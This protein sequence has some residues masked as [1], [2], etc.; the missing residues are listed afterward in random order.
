MSR[1]DQTLAPR[2]DLSSRE[3]LDRSSSRIHSAPS[4]PHPPGECSLPISTPCGIGTGHV[5][6]FTPVRTYLRSAGA[7]HVCE[8]A[9]TPPS[10]EPRSRYHHVGMRT[11][12]PDV[13]WSPVLVAALRIRN[14][15]ITIKNAHVA[16]KYQGHQACKNLTILITHI[17]AWS[18]QSNLIGPHPAKGT[19][20]LQPEPLPQ[21]V[22]PCMD[23][24][25]VV[26]GF[27]NHSWKSSETNTDCGRMPP[28][29]RS[30]CRDRP[31]TLSPLTGASISDA[32]STTPCGSNS[33]NS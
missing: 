31:V 3:N 4:A 33:A 23:G 12:V 30:I 5:R 27:D 18:W 13:P 32:V 11:H 8:M 17:R 14:N 25:K 22:Y 7:T 24:T 9:T 19:K 2:G 26:M 21:R 6:Q 20:P 15:H 16:L 1:D 28:Q 10:R 29:S